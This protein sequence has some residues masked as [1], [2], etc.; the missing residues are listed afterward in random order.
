MKH[1]TSFEEEIVLYAAPRDEMAVRS[2]DSA[3]FSCLS[4][5][6]ARLTKD[7]GTAR[8]PGQIKLTIIA[9]ST[10]FSNSIVQQCWPTMLANTV[11][12]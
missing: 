7:R 3:F 10:P 8:S 2:L 9:K 5:S 4:T 1:N 6:R 11:V 12:V